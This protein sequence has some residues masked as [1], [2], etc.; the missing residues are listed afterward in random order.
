MIRRLKSHHAFCAAANALIALL[1]TMTMTMAVSPA[2]ALP[3]GLQ[4]KA[5]TASCPVPLPSTLP[6]FI[7]PGP[8]AF[9]PGFMKSIKDYGAVGDG[10][11]D[12][13]AAILRGLQ[14]Q[15]E[16]DQDYF[17]RT[18]RLFFPAGVY[19]VSDTL[20]WRGCCVT[21]QGAGPGVS[22]IR[23]KDAAA[24]FGDVNAP[25]P[26]IKTISGNMAF[27]QNVRDLAVSVG[28][29]NAG[30]VGIDWISSN[31][32][33]L[34][35]LVIR[36]ED[37]QG[38]VGLDMT[39]QWPGPSLTKNLY[40][41]GFDIGISVRH[42]EYGPTFEHI[43]LRDQR[44]VGILNNGNTLAIRGLASI[45][46]VPGIQ[47]TQ[48][49]GSIILLDSTFHGGASGVSAIENAGY[50][51]ARNVITSGY[52]SALRNGTTIVAGV[53]LEEYLSSKPLSLFNAAPASKSL[54]LP[55]KDAPAYVDADLANWA[56]W[57]PTCYGCDLGKIQ[58]VMN[59]GKSTVSFPGATLFAYDEVAV[60]VP[61]SVKRIIGFNANLNRGGGTNGG[62][63]KLII[64]SN[65]SEPLIIEE[66]VGMKVE[67]RGKRPIAL[68]YG[69]YSYTNNANAGDL[70]IEDAG[71]APLTVQPGQNV[72]ARQYNNELRGTKIT[73]NGGKLWILGLKT[74][75]A[76][77]VIET[78]NGGST[79]LLGTL[80][81]PATQVPA[82]DVAF[83]IVDSRASFIYSISSYIQNGNYE[84]QVEE[85]RA[86]VTKQ[87]LRRDVGSRM[88]LYVGY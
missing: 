81:Y 42:A 87:L 52:A 43:A 47:N 44:R 8:I 41:Q 88:G 53:V 20:S 21:L 60:V 26:V 19:L 80:I 73:N 17:G 65:A 9:P 22:V 82:T 29:G 14:D 15:R 18:K 5:A 72:W 1:F 45:N 31:I 4:L 39:R 13:T 24:G 77:T 58:G 3:S 32:G 28:S 46:T 33:S 30:A 63:F 74:E 23:L 86:G 2:H 11:T 69:S 62:G 35:N 10:V 27:F 61:D 56:Q 54:A 83:K 6:T 40:V 55:I 50:V 51:Y 48:S 85:A 37:G 57:Q 36:S 66:F 78:I 64:E 34:R 79:E 76:G 71:F 16:I 70:Y 38:A 75:A 68:K 12:D 49:F 25:K 7:T 67:H 84:I 59:S